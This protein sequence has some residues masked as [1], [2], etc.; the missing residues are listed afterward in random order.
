MNDNVTEIDQYPVRIWQTFK[1]W[2]LT[3]LFLD[4][5]R[6]MIGNRAHMTGRAARSDDHNISE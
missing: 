5:F 6:H 4:F 2:R 3:G 1:L